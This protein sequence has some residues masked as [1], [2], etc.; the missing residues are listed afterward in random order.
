MNS[1]KQLVITSF[2]TDINKATSVQENHVKRPGKNDIVVKTSYVGIN[3]LYDRELYRGAVPYID[4]QFP[5][6][7]GVES[8]GQVIE[9]GQN[10]SK[11]GIGD[12][13]GIVKVGSAYQEYQTVHEDI[14]SPLP[15]ATPEYLAI[16]PTGISADLAIEKV[17]EVV[18]GETVLV[19]AAA[20]GLGH[21]IVQLC[22]MKGCHVI[23]TCGHDE[24]VELLE[25]L[26]S[27]DRIIQYNRE[28]LG[29]VLKREY[30]G[31][32]DVAFDTVGAHMFDTI[33]P[34]LALKGRH[35]ICGLAAELSR[36]SFEVVTT[37]RAYE[38][39]Y[40]KGA[41]IRCFMNHLFKDHH[42]ESRSRLEHLYQEGLLKVLIDPMRFEGI[43]NIV[44]ASLY[45]LAGKSRGKVVVSVAEV[46]TKI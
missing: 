4:V 16:S 33:L 10:V 24:K 26:N 20:G 46:G 13:V 34:H 41:S 1:N 37:T 42:G 17:G 14:A 44:D 22:K 9:V 40:W 7:F 25:S 29:E 38:S 12:H 6:V 32:I 19:T 3:A 31:R 36:S 27:C 30:K 35:V 23:A 45:L 15:A 21:F 5:Y 28:D 11:H 39:I 8:V 43:E 18:E 2:D